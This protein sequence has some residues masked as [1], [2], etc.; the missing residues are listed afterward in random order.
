MGGGFWDTSDLDSMTIFIC[1]GVFWD[2]SDLDSMTIFILGGI[3]GHLRFGLYDNFHLGGGYSGTPRIWTLWQFS[4]WGEGRG[5]AGSCITDSLSHTTYVETN[6]IVSLAVETEKCTLNT[7]GS[8]VK[9]GYLVARGVT[10]FVQIQFF[11]N[12]FWEFTATW[13]GIDNFTQGEI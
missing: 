6:K 7:Q 2:T 12:K 3:L 4:F 9:R 5:R 8:W 11:E 13:S 1:G 10:L